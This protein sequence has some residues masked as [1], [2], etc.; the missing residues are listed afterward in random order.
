MLQPQARL[1]V[2]EAAARRG[3]AVRS[4]SVAVALQRQ[5]RL[6]AVALQ[7]V[8]AASSL[9]SR[10]LARPP[11][12]P[13]LPQRAASLLAVALRRRAEGLAPCVA[14]NPRAAAQAVDVV[15]K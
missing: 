14:F 2:G 1:A 10:S 15:N 7:P 5:T 3:A 13:R 8:A 9:A 11:P 4:H 12:R 6:A